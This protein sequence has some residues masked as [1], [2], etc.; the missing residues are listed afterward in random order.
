LKAKGFD[1]TGTL[2]IGG[3]IATAG[4]LI[5]VGAT[6]DCRFRAFESKTGKQVWETALPA[7]AHSTPM[8]FLGKDGRQYVAVAAG[9]G[10]FLGAAAGSKIVAFGLPGGTSSGWGANQART[11]PSFAPIPN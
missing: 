6:I 4:G 3:S 10:S 11:T 5:F 2:N 7:C 8:T 1:K 9:G